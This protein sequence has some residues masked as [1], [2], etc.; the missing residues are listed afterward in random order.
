MRRA[1]VPLVLLVVLLTGCSPAP[2]PSPSVSPTADDTSWLAMGPEDTRTFHGAAGQVLLIF[3]DETYDIDGTYASALTWRLSNGYTTDYVVEDDAG[4]LWWY[5][6]EGDWRAGRRGE[7][8]RQVLDASTAGERA[9][10]EFADLTVTL[11]RGTGPV[12]VETPQG[13]YVVDAAAGSTS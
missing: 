6:R 10:V 12:Q 4:T 7:E 9:V 8:P 11:E 1:L 3:V 13:V 2:A 5:G